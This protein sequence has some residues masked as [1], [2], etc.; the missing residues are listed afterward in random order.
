MAS[1]KPIGIANGK[2][3]EMANGKPVEM[4]RQQKQ[5]A[6]NYKHFSV[7]FITWQVNISICSPLIQKWQVNLK[8][9]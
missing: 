9:Q 3:V 1:G 6:N 4:T 7:S 2:T 5:Q 8:K